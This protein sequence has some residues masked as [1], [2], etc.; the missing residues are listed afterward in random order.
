MIFFVVNELIMKHRGKLEEKKIKV[1]NVSC[2]IVNVSNIRIEKTISFSICIIYY[3]I[4]EI[5]FF[6]R[7]NTKE[8]F[9]NPAEQNDKKTSFSYGKMNF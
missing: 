2:T 4:I 6:I 9:L 8:M 5:L 3:V 7:Q 1:E